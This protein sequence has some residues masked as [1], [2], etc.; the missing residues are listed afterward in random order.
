MADDPNVSSQ[1][2]INAECDLAYSSKD[3]D[4]RNATPAENP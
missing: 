1:I 3:F 2:E 4:S